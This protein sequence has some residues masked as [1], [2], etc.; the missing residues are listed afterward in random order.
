MSDRGSDVIGAQRVDRDR[1]SMRSSGLGAALRGF[2]GR[3]AAR[4][5]DPTG[6]SAAASR[7]K[8]NLSA[9]WSSRA[10]N[11]CVDRPK[12]PCARLPLRTLQVDPVEH[13]ERLGAELELRPCRRQLEVLEER[14]V[15]AG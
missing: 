8:M 11:D 2:R 7:Q 14:Q 4:R 9:N 3:A 1:R 12:V 15:R 13:V 5:R 10:G 6:R